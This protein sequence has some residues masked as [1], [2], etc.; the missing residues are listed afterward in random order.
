MS[1]FLLFGSS[2][3]TIGHLASSCWRGQPIVA[4]KIDLGPKEGVEE[5]EKKKFWADEEA[6]NNEDLILPECVNA[7]H[8]DSDNAKFPITKTAHLEEGLHVDAAT[9]LPDQQNESKD[10]S[11]LMN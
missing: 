1:V 8:D 3:K 2:C 6:V 4:A 7:S 11:S 9:V 10:F 5:K